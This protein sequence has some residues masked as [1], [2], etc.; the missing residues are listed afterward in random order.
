MIENFTRLGLQHVTVEKG[1]RSIN[2]KVVNPFASVNRSPDDFKAIT[3]ILK[4]IFRQNHNFHEKNYSKRVP[5]YPASHVDQSGDDSTRRP[6]TSP[7]LLF[8]QTL[9]PSTRPVIS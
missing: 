2:Y 3:E 8:A 7:K 5:V 9:F 1:S 4:E 6:V